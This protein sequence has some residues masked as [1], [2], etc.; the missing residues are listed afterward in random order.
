MAKNI[1]KLLMII[2]VITFI[3]LIIKHYFSDKNK[4]LVENNRNNLESIIQKN[5]KELPL[6]KN[7]TN[8]VIEFN[9]GFNDTNTQNFKRSF[10]D[11][12]K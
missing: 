5:T 1:I 10:W 2:F 6:L 8:N 4:N 12:F 11:L 3:F 7:N 9:S